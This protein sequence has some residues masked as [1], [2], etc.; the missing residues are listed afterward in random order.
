VPLENRAPQAEAALR[1]RRL[2]EVSLLML[3]ANLPWLVVSFAV[4]TAAMN[5]VGAD[6]GRL[7][8]EYGAGGWVAWVLML[9]FMAVPSIVGVILGVRAR[10]SGNRGLGT[11]GIVANATVGVGLILLSA[12]QVAIS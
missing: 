4:G 7:L 1:G 10:G 12:A 6:E 9:G 11:A 3:A 2:A 5:L 8:T